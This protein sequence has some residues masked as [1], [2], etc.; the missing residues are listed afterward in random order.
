MAA[1]SRESQGYGGSESTEGQMCHVQQQTDGSAT[2]EEARVSAHSQVGAVRCNL[3][4][5]EL[6][7]RDHRGAVGTV[8]QAGDETRRASLSDWSTALHLSPTHT[9]TRDLGLGTLQPASSRDSRPR[10]FL[11]LAVSMI[12]STNLGNQPNITGVR[13]CLL[14]EG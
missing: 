2:C 10:S 1:E 4:T 6:L 12:K 13:Y 5:C 8:D 9:H 3:A 7:V 14:R 11:Q